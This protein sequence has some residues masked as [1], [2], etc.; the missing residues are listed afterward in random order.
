MLASLVNQ[1][2]S[3]EKRTSEQKLID[4][5]IKRL[6][7]AA[8]AVKE[9]YQN[10]SDDLK[11]GNGEQWDQGE[12]S[13]RS[14]AGRPSLTVN[15]FPK[16]IDQV[17]GDMRH[18]CPQIKLRPVDTRADVHMARI[19]EGLIAQIQ[20][21]SNARSVY[22][23]G[24]EQAV[25][26]GYGA[27]RVLT[28]WCDDN[29]FL[30]EIKIEAI[31]NPFQVYFDPDAKDFNYA[32][33]RYAFVLEKMPRDEFEDKYPD[34]EVP[35]KDFDVKPGLSNELWFDKDTVTVAEYFEKSSEVVTMCQ[36]DDG[37]YM[38][39]DEAKERIKEWEEE[40]E[41]SIAVPQPSALAPPMPMAPINPNVPPTPQPGTPAALA[42]QAI[43]PAAQRTPQPNMPQLPPPQPAAGAAPP[44]APVG[45]MP[46]G[47]PVAPPTPKPKIVKRRD[48][49]R[50]VIK[51]Y[52]MSCLE[53]LNK[54][55]DRKNEREDKTLERTAD[56]IVGEFIP[57][58]LVKGKVTNIEGKEVVKSLIRDAKDMQKLVNYW[59]TTAAETVALSPKTP[60]LGTAK[61]FEG[62]EADY[63]N[64]N[65]ENIPYLK[66]N[67][68]PEAPAGPQKIPVA[69]PPQ[70]VF[71]QIAVAEQ[72]LKSVIGMFNADVGDAGPERTGAAI[73]ARQRPGD[74]STYVF[75]DNLSSAIAH[76]GRIINSMIPHI[77]DTE[78]DIRLRGVDDSESWVPVNTTLKQAMK[79]VQEHPERY[80]GLDKNRIASAL[81]KYGPDVKF[82]DITVGKYD[83][84]S[85]VG[86]SYATQRQEAA[87]ML[88]K[89]FNSMPQQMGLAADIIVEN[90][91]FK[92]ADRLARRL[93]KTL[94]PNIVE[95]KEGEVLPQPQ[96]N[97]MMIQMQM[98]QQVEQMKIQTQQ[99]KMQMEQMKLEKERLK[100]Q[101]EIEKM[102][103]EM[104][105]AQG[106]DKR[107]KA[108][109]RMMELVERDRRYSIDAERLRLEEA[110]F[111]HQRNLEGARLAHDVSKDAMER[112]N[113]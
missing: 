38:T 15:L 71:Q 36:M 107:E 4:K 66:Y 99:I 100:L 45:P 39:E 104:A 108:M 16:Y 86:P 49:D 79:A 62:Y 84:F 40:F 97:P 109:E 43:N 31:K 76:T 111:E 22:V 67:F 28:D 82:N 33:A 55:K 87:D 102:K 18:N 29:P 23:Q 83:V 1:G 85:T 19:R 81:R 11:F 54:K 93:R 47:G 56:T 6:K 70:A 91:D 42:P 78:R 34:A 17:T 98:K 57:L 7:R 88:F 68:D 25:K 32:D 50:P 24:G 101:F 110:R 9:N 75:M 90:L 21:N 30:Q 96:P 3:V 94:P 95:P 89:M 74:I 13:R 60:W 44:S 65:T 51:H 58:V 112:F 26:S 113:A 52:I 27:W 53:I 2:V 73:N 63:A 69:Q 35:G 106:D 37:T 46:M 72:N 48:L 64:A 80:S 92:D 41:K 8:D 77:Y 61:H 20:Y 10:G 5:A 103:M 12:K 105:Q 14:R 59:H